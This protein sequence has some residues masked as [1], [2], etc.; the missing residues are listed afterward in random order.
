MKKKRA[1]L[2]IR[3]VIL[4]AVI[5]GA[6]TIVQLRLDIR[7]AEQQKA[8]VQLEID[9]QKRENALVREALMNS[10]SAETIAEAARDELGYVSSNERI[11]YDVSN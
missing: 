7:E 8:A 5:W 9:R 3:L 1:G 6:V 2:L 4:A 11:F 10:S